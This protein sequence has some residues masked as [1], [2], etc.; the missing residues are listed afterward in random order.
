MSFSKSNTQGRHEHDDLSREF[1]D[2]FKWGNM[3]KDLLFF[4]SGLT[5]FE[6]RGRG[7]QIE[8]SWTNTS[9]FC[10]LFLFFP[11]L[12]KSLRELNCGMSVLQ[13]LLLYYLREG[14]AGWSRCQVQA[15]AVKIKE[16]MQHAKLPKKKGRRGKKIKHRPIW[17]VWAPL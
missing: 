1:G 11:P 4:C 13:P 9:S 5:C 3:L 2:S 8:D 16:Y 10:P 14:T 7:G 6:T 17:I 12:C 15:L